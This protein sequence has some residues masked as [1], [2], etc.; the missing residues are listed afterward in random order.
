MMQNDPC[1]E[2]NRL[3]ERFLSKTKEAQDMQ[4]LRSELLYLTLYFF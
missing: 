2:D 3:F 4:R 1:G